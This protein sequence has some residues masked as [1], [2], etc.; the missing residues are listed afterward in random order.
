MVNDAKDVAVKT[1]EALNPVPVKGVVM[2]IVGCVENP[3]D[4][5]PI[6]AVIVPVAYT[7]AT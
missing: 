3:L 4:V 7:V 5:P 2:V 6:I 1:A